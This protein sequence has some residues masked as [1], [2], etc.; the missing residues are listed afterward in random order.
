MN[1][2]LVIDDDE[3]ILEVIRISLKF[4]GF[5]VKA[6]SSATNI[7]QVVRQYQP[8]LILLDIILPGKSGIQL[9]KELKNLNIEIPLIL[10]S[11]AAKQ[12]KDFSACKADDFISKPF[13]ILHLVNTIKSHL[14]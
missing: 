13:D 9:C 1:K 3:D 7:H 4:Y 12:G 8:S 11:A 6:L 2:I 10:F 14:K 5:D